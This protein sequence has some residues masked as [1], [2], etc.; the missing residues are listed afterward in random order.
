MTFPLYNT[1]HCTPAIMRNAA[2]FPSFSHFSPSAAF[3]GAS[4]PGNFALCRYCC[5]C[6]SE[7]RSVV[8][9]VPFFLVYNAN[10]VSRERTNTDPLQSSRAHV[11]PVQCLAGSYEPRSKPVNGVN[12]AWILLCCFRFLECILCVCRGEAKVLNLTI[13]S[14]RSSL[15]A[16]HTYR[17]E[18]IFLRTTRD[19]PATKRE[20]GFLYVLNKDP[21]QDPTI[22]NTLIQKRH[23]C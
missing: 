5:C 18:L 16:L 19:D 23:H 3:K 9:A 22:V 15:T 6:L 21:L 20:K 14:A 17:L 10:L 7:C 2:S 13:D 8:W 4:R 12:N 1:Y 11:G